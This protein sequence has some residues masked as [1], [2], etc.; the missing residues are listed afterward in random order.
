MGGFTAA[1]LAYGFEILMSAGEV[2]DALKQMPEEERG[3]VECISSGDR[4][5]L[6]ANREVVD[7][8]AYLNLGAMH[9]MVGGDWDTE[10]DRVAD[11]LGH[12]GHD[13]PGWMAITI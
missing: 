9:R 7:L 13:V 1:Y 5:F 12:S 3:H 4:V 6:T 11:R 10:L 8:V 2:E